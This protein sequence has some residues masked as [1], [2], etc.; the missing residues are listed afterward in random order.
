MEIW[1]KYAVILSCMIFFAVNA[2]MV[3]KKKISSEKGNVWALLML[4]GVGA[5][6]TADF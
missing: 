3:V 6:V 5:G 1:F 2:G 4:L